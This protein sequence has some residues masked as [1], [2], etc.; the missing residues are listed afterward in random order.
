VFLGAAIAWHESNALSLALLSLTMLAALC[1]HA[2][3]NMA[4]DY[5]D[6]ISGCDTHP[7]YDEFS[8]PFFGGSR[9]L[10]EGQL[11]ARE[12]HRAALLAIGLGIGVGLYIVWRVGWPILILGL[13]GVL[14]GY[15][16]VTC[17]APRGLGEV[18]VFLNFGPLMVL[19]SQY[20]Q[21]GHFSAEALLASMPVGILIAAVL[22]INEVSDFEADKAAGKDTLV[23]RLGRRRAADVY[24]ALMAAAYAL[25]AILS[26]SGAIPAWGLI[27]LASLPLALRSIT[28]ARAHHESPSAMVSANAGTVMAHAVTGLLL[29]LA[30]PIFDWL[31]PLI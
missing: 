31:S 16:Y 17:L 5:F 3:S 9:L 25:I 13:I 23:V 2:G 24:A 7:Q 28:I 14:S 30:Y 6:Y 15:L 29:A 20:A 11:Q 8:A 21:V 27:S 1:L 18:S 4:N 10:P 19:G 22:W 26:L 12:V